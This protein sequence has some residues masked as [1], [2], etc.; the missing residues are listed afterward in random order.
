MRGRGLKILR[1][2]G[3]AVVFAGLTAALVDFRGAVPGLVGHT[4]ASIQ[5]VPSAVALATGAGV[6]LACLVVLAVTFA[7][8]RI[9]CSVICPLGI[10]QDLAT[11]IAGWIWPKKRPRPYRPASTIVRQAFLWGAVVGVAAGWAGLTL[12]LLDPYSVFGRIAADLFRPAVTL[13]NN[14]LVGTVG[15]FT[16]EALYR[17]A[18][19]WAGAGALAV[20]AAMLLFVAGLAAWRGRLYC[21]TVCPVGTVLGFVSARGAWRLAIDQAACRKCGDCL[22]VCKAQC[23]DLRHGVI[24]ASRCVDCYNCIGACS[25]HGIAYRWSWTRP[26]AEPATATAAAAPI[27]LQRRAFVTASAAAL[28]T[29]AGV[30]SW[31]MT[32]VVAEVAAGPSSAP[33]ADTSPN[34]SDVICPPGAGGVDQFLN[35]CTACH[36]CLSACPTHVLQPAFLE[37]GFAG[38]LKPRLDYAGAF[39]NFDCRRCAEVCPDGALSILTLADKQVTRIGAAQ[40]NLDNCIVKTKGTDCAAC[41]EHCPTKAVDTVPYGNNLRLPQVNADLCIGCGACEYACPAK[42]RKAITV[43]G[44]RTHE[45]AIRRVEEKAKDPR[46]AGEFPF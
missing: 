38:L 29:A 8:G 39:C 24:D 12:S 25:E 2:A 41:S 45:R 20:P 22:R 43:A 30:G 17:V 35:R 33:P 26:R 13:V 4:F 11:R 18:P 27:D 15:R 44:R 7:V 28:T 1:V 3:A 46:R 42:P 14:A 36:L 5:F 37:Y 6:A 16:G 10:L 32:R 9:Y 21:N 40:L 23:I 19:A 34:R 31:A